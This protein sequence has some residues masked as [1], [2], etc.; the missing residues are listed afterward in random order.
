MTSDQPA[1][2]TCDIIYAAL[3][4]SCWPAGCSH[5]WTPLDS[6]TTLH[7][8]SQSPF[9]Q[10][11]QSSICSLLVLD[12]SSHHCNFSTVHVAFTVFEIILTQ[13]FIFKLKK[14]KLYVKKENLR[15]E[16]V[17]FGIKVTSKFSLSYDCITSLLRLIIVK[18]FNGGANDIILRRNATIFFTFSY[19]ISPMYI[20]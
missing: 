5:Q 14:K 9:N 11:S 3:R 10:K 6:S 1:G 19:S 20:N 18:T 4:D 17:K 8:F 2:A 15:L 13:L 16:S 7:P 12:S